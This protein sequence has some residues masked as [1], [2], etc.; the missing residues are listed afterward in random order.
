MS[1]EEEPEP[2][3][4]LPQQEES[5]QLAEWVHYIPEPFSEPLLSEGV[6]DK[7]WLMSQTQLRG[8]VNAEGEHALG[9]HTIGVLD[10]S[11]ESLI[12][13]ANMYVDGLND[14]IT[15]LFQSVKDLSDNL[16]QFFVDKNRQNALGNGV[17]AVD[18]AKTIEKVASAEIEKEVAEPEKEQI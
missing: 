14:Q 11:Q 16:N 10:V 6:S 7:G 9:L 5:E 18:N 1:V 15:V 8:A 12:K 13:T 2:E 17:E 4:E 3:P